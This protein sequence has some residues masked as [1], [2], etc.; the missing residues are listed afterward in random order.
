MSKYK[1][2]RSQKNAIFEAL[3]TANIN[4]FDIELY[5]ADEQFKLVHKASGHFFEINYD[6]GLF[7]YAIKYSP[8]NEVWSYETKKDLWP[9][10]LSEAKSWASYLGREVSQPDYW[11]DI[12]INA[13]NLSF[14]S[15]SDAENTAFSEP[16]KIDI[17]NKLNQIEG[18][19]INNY[20]LSEESKKLISDKLDSLELLSDSQGRKDWLHTAIGVSFTIIF[21]VGLAPAQ[22]K[23]FANFVGHILSQVYN[24]A[25]PL[26]P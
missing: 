1:L 19:L 4:H 18:F 25:L 22:A 7:N 21:A 20:V 17:R 13:K 12:V 26:L 5:D 16:E 23:E 24:G 8:G 11:S 3:K 14:K 15:A 10:V 2:L 6:T 9:N